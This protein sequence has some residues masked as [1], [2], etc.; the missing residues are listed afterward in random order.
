MLHLPTYARKQQFNTHNSCS[1]KAKK[2]HFGKFVRSVIFG[3]AQVLKQLVNLARKQPQHFFQ[4][5]PNLPLL[6]FPFHMFT[7]TASWIE[8]PQSGFNRTLP[9]NRLTRNLSLAIVF[10]LVST[11]NFGKIYQKCRILI[12]SFILRR[13]HGMLK[14]MAISQLRRMTCP[15]RD[16]WKVAQNFLSESQLAALQKTQNFRR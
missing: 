3:V 5:S 2:A 4:P 1:N 16:H 9:T 12:Q 15:A 7:F 10:L 13:S 11:K 6:C 8:L 14:K